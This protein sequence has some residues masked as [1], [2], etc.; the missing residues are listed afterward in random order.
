[1]ENVIEDDEKLKLKLA[2]QGHQRKIMRIAL[3]G[4]ILLVSLTGAIAVQATRG[5]LDQ[6]QTGCSAAEFGFA[7]P[8]PTL[9]P[10][11]L[12][13][14]MDRPLE[15]AS[16]E[17]LSQLMARCNMTWLSQRC[18]QDGCLPVN[19]QKWHPEDSFWA[20]LEGQATVTELPYAIWVQVRV[21]MREVLGLAEWRS[22]LAGTGQLNYFQLPAG[23]QLL[24]ITSE[25][26]EGEP[27][28]YFTKQNQLSFF[29][30]VAKQ[31]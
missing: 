30:F 26:H 31:P 14:R 20:I 10:G 12:G 25:G 15:V 18:K 16:L 3:I 7:V 29:P 13:Y 2:R 8:L 4:A 17:R 27:G 5:P 28:W 1:M 6:V 9:P 23:T 22:D 19:T 24:A 11:S 21:D